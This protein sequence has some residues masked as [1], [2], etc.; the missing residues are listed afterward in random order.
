MLSVFLGALS[1]FVISV[2]FAFMYNVVPRHLVWVGM[3]G[4]V[5]TACVLICSQHFDAR[6]ANALAAV[7]ISSAAEFLARRF[8]CPATIFSI[9]ALIPLV[10]GGGIYQT[11]LAT[12]Q[13]DR[14]LAGAYASDT[15]QIT[16][17]LVIG[18]L[19][20]TSLRVLWQRKPALEPKRE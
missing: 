18:M 19:L 8:Q 13:G 2:C 14:V 12:I 4:A 9:A 7:C 11:M 6:V 5:G 10:P 16:A 15:L 1:A 20:V 3:T 17:A